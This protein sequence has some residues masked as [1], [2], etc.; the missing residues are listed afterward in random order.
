MVL[1]GL[2]RLYLPGAPLWDLVHDLGPGPSPSGRRAVCLLTCSPW[3]Y[4]RSH[5]RYSILGKWYS[6]SNPWPGVLAAGKCN[7][8]GS[9]CNPE[10]C[11]LAVGKN[12]RQK[13]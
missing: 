8:L 9:V 11:D 10:P 6:D 1:T 5:G 7:K 2:V 12:N 13:S 4:V 3:L